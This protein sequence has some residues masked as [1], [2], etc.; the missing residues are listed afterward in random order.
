MSKTK[1]WVKFEFFFPSILWRNGHAIHLPSFASFRLVEIGLHLCCS[2]Q[3]HTSF[4]SWNWCKLTFGRE[5]VW[6]TRWQTENLRYHRK[7]A[8][9]PELFWKM[10]MVDAK[11]P[12]NRT[13]YALRPTNEKPFASFLVV[14]NDWAFF[15]HDIG[16]KPSQ[17]FFD[18]Q[19][20]SMWW[21]NFLL[22]F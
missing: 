20:Q 16:E 11:Q 15:D 17:L 5:N 1:L 8:I 2:K 19:M 22:V 9:E 13:A 3:F 7:R 14:R 10:K 18:I 4:F 12:E 21:F 6:Y